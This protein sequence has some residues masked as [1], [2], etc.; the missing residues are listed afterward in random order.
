LQ[1]VVWASHVGAG[2]SSF[3]EHYYIIAKALEDVLRKTV[4]GVL[5]ISLALGLLK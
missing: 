3:F 1:L 5:Q 4:A 2:S